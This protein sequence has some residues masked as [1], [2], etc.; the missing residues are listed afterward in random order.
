MNWNEIFILVNGQLEHH[1]SRTAP[2]IV[3]GVPVGWDCKG[4]TKVKYQGKQYFAHRVIWEMNN[5]PIPEGQEIDHIDG[6]KS[7]N[8][9]ENLRLANRSQNCAN[10]EG[11]S[12]SGL[13]RGLFFER[14]RIRAQLTV[15]GKMIY[16]GMFSVEDQELAELVVSEARVKYHGDF[17]RHN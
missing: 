15:N 13:P 14:G 17:A 3:H 4:Y 1:P 6:N 7:N 12:K 16:L 10:R 8:C 9:I 2:R 5:G 11:W